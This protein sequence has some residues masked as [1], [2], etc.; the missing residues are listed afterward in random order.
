M[1][2]PQQFRANNIAEKEEAISPLDRLSAPLKGFLATVLLEAMQAEL[3]EVNVTRYIYP[4]S[5]W[6]LW[7]CR[8]VDLP[9]MKQ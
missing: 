3:E 8:I 9:H 1:G 7:M 2:T 5:L 4:L 6:I